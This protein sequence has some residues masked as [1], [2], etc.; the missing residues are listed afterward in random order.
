MMSDIKPIK[1]ITDLFHRINRLSSEADWTEEELLQALTEEGINP[2]QLLE[3]VR[4]DVKHLLTRS[5]YYW[6]NRART[7][8]EMLEGRVRAQDRQ[9]SERLPRK[10]LLG[11]IE[12]TLAR[13][14]P[15]IAQQFALEHRNFGECTDEDLRSILIELECIEKLDASDANK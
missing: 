13:M 5:P 3:K 15:S 9:L 2:G 10:E 12:A 11:H 4:S 7:L 8:R 1:S 6:R 14:P